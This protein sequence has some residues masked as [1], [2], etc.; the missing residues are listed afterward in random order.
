MTS[1]YVASIDAAIARCADAVERARLEARKATYFARQGDRDG[2]QDIVARLRREFATRPDAEVSATL[3]LVEGLLAFFGD[4][5]PA[6]AGSLQRA[7]ALAVAGGVDRVLALAAAWLAHMD[8]STH[9]F[10]GMAGHLERAL[11]KADADNHDALSRA[12]LVCA[13]AIHLGGDYD[14]A[15]P[16]YH[17]ARRHS[18]EAGDDATIAAC[19]HNMVAIGFANVRQAMLGGAGHPQPSL[20]IL[21]GARSARTYDELIGTSSLDMLLP[22]LRAGILSLKGEP[23]PAF[24]LYRLNID[25]ARE[26][27]GGRMVPWYLA[28]M[29]SCQ[30]RL[31]RRE[32]ARAFATQAQALLAVPERTQCDDAAA[33]HS[34]LMEVFSGLGDDAQAAA[35]AASAARAWADFVRVQ[36]HLLEITSGIARR[37][38]ERTS[39]VAGQVES[40]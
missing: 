37:F 24:E 23:E 40:G 15:V 7:Q 39:C 35:H 20:D 38:R 22:L 12:S 28:D 26:H 8:F 11:Q 29:A 1:R 5:N 9:R 21:V 25:G 27:A 36:K 34:R 13:M 18:L 33:S 30:L 2:A 16:W 14:A 31:G 32:D 6:A 19:M 4:L 10:D 17:A 3:H